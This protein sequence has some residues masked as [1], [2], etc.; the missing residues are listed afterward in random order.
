MLSCP[1]HH[2]PWLHSLVVLDVLIGAVL[3]KRVNDSEIPH[4]HSEVQWSISLVIWQVGI[5]PKFAK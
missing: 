3:Q 2:L 1:V 5:D 4:G